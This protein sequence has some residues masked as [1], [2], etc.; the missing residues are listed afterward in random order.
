MLATLVEGS[1]VSAVI[2]N[3]FLISTKEF[4]NS[5]RKDKTKDLFSSKHSKENKWK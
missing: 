4:I 5:Q 2:E 3:T 1:E